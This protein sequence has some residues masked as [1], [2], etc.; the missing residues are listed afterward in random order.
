[1]SIR[2][3]LIDYHYFFPTDDILVGDEDDLDALHQDVHDD[4]DDLQTHPR[5][6]TPTKEAP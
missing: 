4:E 6:E 3:H 1:M 2:Q 5:H